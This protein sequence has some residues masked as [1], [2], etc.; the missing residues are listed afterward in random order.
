MGLKAGI[1]DRLLE[2]QAPSLL[3]FFVFTDVSGVLEG[4]HTGSIW[5][6][7]RVPH[8]FYAGLIRVV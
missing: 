4:L 7:F 8:G 2:G 5:V 6:P 3:F 1:A